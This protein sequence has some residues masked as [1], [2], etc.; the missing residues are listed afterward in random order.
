MNEGI[1]P[2]SRWARLVDIHRRYAMRLVMT[3]LSPGKRRI[4]N[5]IKA[6][7]ENEEL[8]ICGPTLGLSEALLVL[9]ASGT[10]AVNALDG[11]VDTIRRS[12]Q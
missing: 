4:Y 8:A 5:R 6:A 10:K 9:E 7:I 1:G 11:L 2:G 12:K 3:G